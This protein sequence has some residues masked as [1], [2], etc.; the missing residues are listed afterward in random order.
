MTAQINDIQVVW[1]PDQH[2]GTSR[3]QALALFDTEHKTELSDG[4]STC[5]MVKH[6]IV[7]NHITAPLTRLIKSQVH[8]AKCVVDPTVGSGISTMS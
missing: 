3:R 8:V 2:I 4:S 6:D 7:S 1:R 5:S